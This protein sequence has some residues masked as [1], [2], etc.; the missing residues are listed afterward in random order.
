M[1]VKQLDLEL[2]VTQL[3]LLDPVMRSYLHRV[4]ANAP[5]SLHRLMRCPISSQLKVLPRGGGGGSSKGTGKGGKA[6]LS[7][8]EKAADAASKRHAAEVK[9]LTR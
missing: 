2:K 5:G 3:K 6:A 9:H 8:E 4:A 7:A 1:Q